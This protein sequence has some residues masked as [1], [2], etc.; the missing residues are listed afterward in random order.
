MKK[1][2][3]CNSYSTVVTKKFKMILVEEYLYSKIAV[4]DPVTLPNNELLHRYFPTFLIAV[5][6]WYF[7][8]VYW[9]HYTIVS[10]FHR[11][12]EKNNNILKGEYQK[13]G[14]KIWRGGGGRTS[15]RYPLQSSYACNFL[16]TIF[17]TCTYKLMMVIR[18]R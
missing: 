4:L 8:M 2:C 3:L 1:D 7:L 9:S 10:R 17:S 6:E 16:H 15:L 18:K 13:R 12:L 5:V 11:S 14:N